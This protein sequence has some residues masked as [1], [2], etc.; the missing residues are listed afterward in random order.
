[1]DC[2]VLILD[3]GGEFLNHHLWAYMRERRTPHRIYPLAA[4]PLG[5][6]RPRRTKELDV[7]TATSG[8]RASGRS[9]NWWISPSAPSPGGVGNSW[10]N[11]FLPC[12]KLTKSGAKVQSLAQALKSHPGWPANDSLCPRHAAFEGASAIAGAPRQPRPLLQLKDELEAKLKLIMLPKTP[13]AAS[14]QA[15]GI[16]TAGGR[17]RRLEG[18]PPPARF[19]SC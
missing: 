6:Q 19:I 17:E 5:R 13:H 2:W 15:P 1:M 4:L 18:S 12:L 9:S 16:L 14:P 3:N 7:G 10:Q 11:F 8:L